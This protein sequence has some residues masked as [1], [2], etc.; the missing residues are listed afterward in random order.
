MHNKVFCVNTGVVDA[1]YSTLTSADGSKKN[2]NQDGKSEDI[3]INI[4]QLI[5]DT[6]KFDPALCTDSTFILLF[7]IK[8]LKIATKSIKD[9]NP[10][11]R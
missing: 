7:L 8:L 6:N 5:I 11:S 2:L 9:N 10:V 4:I 1:D 3:F